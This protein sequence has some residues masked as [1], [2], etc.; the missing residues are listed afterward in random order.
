MK[1]FL[2]GAFVACFILLLVFVA[3]I[4]SNIYNVFP[5]VILGGLCGIIGTI[6]EEKGY[7]E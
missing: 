7:V 2:F 3:A 4:D 5:V 6:I 1:Y